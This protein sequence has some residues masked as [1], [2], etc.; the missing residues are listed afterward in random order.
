MMQEI[1]RLSL[2]LVIS[3]IIGLRPSRGVGPVAGRDAGGSWES[4][5][6]AFSWKGLLPY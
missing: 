1:D 2:E 5:I 3:R 4:F 6:C